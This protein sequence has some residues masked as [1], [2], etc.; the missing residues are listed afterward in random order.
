MALYTT[1]IIYTR[2]RDVLEYCKEC[3]VCKVTNKREETGTHTPQDSEDNDDS[4]LVKTLKAEENLTGGADPDWTTPYVQY[5]TQ[6]TK[7]ESHLPKEE[8]ELIVYRSQF[9]ILKDG[10]LHRIFHNNVIKRCMPGKYVR[11][12]IKTFHIR[13]NQ[14]YSI[15]AT[16]KL[17]LQE[18]YWWPT[19]A[20]DIS[21]FITLCTRCRE[22]REELATEG[23]PHEPSTLKSVISYRETLNAWRTP[24]IQ[25]LTHG[26]IKVG[27]LTKSEHREII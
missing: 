13:E 6:R 27:T 16:K 12:Y 19:I 7:W 21:L 10:E 2:Q 4:L 8:K 26:E 20:E 23:G 24:L 25:Y 1:H 14:H 18:S 17:I 9:F 3:P 11:N 5:M 22:K 15:N